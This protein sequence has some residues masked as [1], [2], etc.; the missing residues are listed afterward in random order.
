MW[1]QIRIPCFVLICLLSLSCLSFA[2]A[3]EE[4]LTITTYYPS[5]YGV[6]KTLRLFPNT[7][8]GF[9]PDAVCSINEEGAMSYD[10][11]TKQVLVCVNDAGA[12]SWRTNVG[13]G[14]DSEWKTYVDPI[15]KQ[16]RFQRSGEDKVKFDPYSGGIAA[17]R[18]HSILPSYV[19]LGSTGNPE[20]VL[21]Y[22]DPAIS[23]NTNWKVYVDVTDANKFKIWYR[24]SA[25]PQITLD[26]AG[27]LGIGTDAPQ[28]KLDVEGGI[29]IG[30]DLIACDHPSK[31]GRMRYDSG[32]VQYCNGSSWQTLGGGGGLIGYE[33][34]QD[35]NTNFAT[36]TCSAGK[37]VLGGGCN[38]FGVPLSVNAPAGNNGWSCVANGSSGVTAYAIC[39]NI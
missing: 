6:Y 17:F 27:N 19:P 30:N 20:L 21:W 11:D 25:N 33:I 2:A 14:V 5:P 16:L 1:T 8:T 39:A 24:P 15:T 38:S 37:K 34:V 31:A 18:F 22:A 9:A 23:A 35:S 28:A 13:F 29:K 10:S 26:T 12:Y 3:N 32:S 4:T 36:V 7:D